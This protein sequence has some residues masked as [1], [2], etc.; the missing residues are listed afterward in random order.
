ME[1]GRWGISE[2]K[3]TCPPVNPQEI[4][5]ILIPGV[6][7]DCDGNRLGYG[8][9]FYDRFL[10]LLKEDVPRIGWTF[11]CQ[12]FERIPAEPHD[13]TMRMLISEEGIFPCLHKGRG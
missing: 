4:D 1:S 12:I 11:F 6:A 7:F 9:G 10:P 13:Q 2:P 3:A 5:L 8:A